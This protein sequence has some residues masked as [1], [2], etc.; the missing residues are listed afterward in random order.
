MIGHWDYLGLMAA[1]LL[2]TLPLELVFA[3]RVYRRWQVL[4][5]ALVPVVVVFAVWD[6]IAIARDHWSY[7]PRFVTG[8]DLGI[9]PLE[10]LVFFLVIP[11][12]A[13][14]SYEAVGT[15]IGWTRRRTGSRTNVAHPREP[16]RRPPIDGEIR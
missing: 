6:I 1:C 10:E 11:V 4:L 7:D 14:L 16:D 13:L 3:A 9:L 15:V 8:I 2:I 5:K 12:C